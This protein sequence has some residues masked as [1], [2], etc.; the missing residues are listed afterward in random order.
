MG[1]T[2]SPSVWVVR[3][4]GLIPD[5]SRVLDLACGQGRHTR[6]MIQLGHQVLAVDR[7]EEKLLQVA[8]QPGV[9]TLG[10]DLETGPW[11]L[12]NESFHGIVVSN[13][14]HRP[15]LPRLVDVLEKD[16]ILIYDT[17]AVGNEVYGRPSN[18][19][20]LLRPGELLNAFCPPLHAVAYE[21]GY[22]RKPEQA[23]RQRLCAARTATPLA[24]RPIGDRGDGT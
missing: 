19:D 18:P 7:D 10:A 15:L 1:Q 6:L 14:L 23:V 20:Y 9:T 12:E 16:G 3:F 17:F 13:Y 22:T 5:G 24:L 2:E 11:P 4:A 21:H 8:S